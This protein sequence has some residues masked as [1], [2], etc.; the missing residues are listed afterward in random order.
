RGE[1]RDLLR[2]LAPI[3]AAF[4]QLEHAPSANVRISIRLCDFLSVAR[5]VIENDPLTQRQVAKRDVRC[6]EPA[7]ERVE[8]DA[9]GDREI[10]APWLQAWY[11]EPLLEIA[12]DDLLSHAPNLLRGD[13]SISQR[14]GRLSA[15]GE[16]DGANAL[17][18]ARRADDPVEALPDDLT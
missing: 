6:A 4:R 7:H 8:Q 14:A 16:R 1:L 13:S 15:L 9:A 3:V 5:D 10:R 17:D 18:G 12:S 2:M 11:S